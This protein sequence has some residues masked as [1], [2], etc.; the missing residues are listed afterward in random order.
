MRI[1]AFL[2]LLLI[3]CSGCGKSHNDNIITQPDPEKPV[4]LFPA[5]NAACT[6]SSV[7]SATQSSVQLSWATAKNA[8]SYDVSLKNLISGE[9]IIK[10]VNDSKLLLSLT[11]ST[12]YSW[13]VTAKSTKSTATAQ[14]ETWK[15]YNPG[16]GATYYVPFPADAVAPANGE[17]LSAVA[18]KIDLKW[19]GGDADNDII[20]YEVYLGTTATGMTILESN[21]TNMFLTGVSVTPGTKYYWKVV[22]KDARG[23]ES[24]SATFNF[25]VN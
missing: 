13:A 21:V 10:N 22:T 7:L 3:I 16:P 24:N 23:N 25:S 20:G 14:S 5:E 18:G 15:F 2:L 8:D 6:P 19:K 4:L 11:R 12:P 1:S 9:V 17:S